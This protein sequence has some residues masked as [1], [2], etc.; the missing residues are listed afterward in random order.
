ML[1]E[2]LNDLSKT[3]EIISVLIPARNE[4]NRL[5]NLLNDLIK[6]TDHN[7]EIIV[8]DDQS[9]D[10]T[11]EVVM[12]FA[13]RDKRIKL[14]SSDGLPNGWLGKNYA[15]YNLAKISNGNYLL[16]LDADVN[17]TANIIY[18][19]VNYLKHY[20]LSLLSIFPHQKMITIGEKLTVPLMNFIL[21]SLLPLILV[22]KTTFATLS[23]A[24][25][26]FML[27]DAN[28]YKKYNPHL[29]FKNNKV[30]DIAIVR[31]FK[32]NKNRVACLLGNEEISC[33]MYEKFM[34][35]VNG[36]AKNVFYFFGNSVIL[37][38]LFWLVITLGFLPILASFNVIIFILYI[39]IVFMT[40]II[41]SIIS[42]Q[43]ILMN[44]LYL[45]PQNLILGLIIFKALMYKINKQVYI[46]KEREVL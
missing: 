10:R 27:F 3:D 17:V 43:S 8:F 15:C 12:K 36:F 1:K 2:R 13:E 25:G 24:N 45:I 28:V 38:I 5:P 4:E 6:I 22:R 34:D 14:I 31:F 21:L 19:A 29:F 16:F 11:Q 41:I 33:R 26:Q 35:A 39:L 37:A 23:A 32:K 42:K 18:R 7:I 40:R 44:L 46:W 9:T 30:E 20:N